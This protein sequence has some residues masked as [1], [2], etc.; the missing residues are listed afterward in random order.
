MSDVLLCTLRVNVNGFFSCHCFFISFCICILF[1]CIAGV[2]CAVMSVLCYVQ[3]VLGAALP[4][5]SSLTRYDQLQNPCLPVQTVPV[6][7][8][9]EGLVL[10]HYGRLLN[11]LHPISR[12]NTALQQRYVC[13]SITQ[14]KHSGM[15]L[16][17]FLCYS[18]H[19]VKQ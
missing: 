3:P 4:S 8:A 10:A 14:Y 1:H 6:Q 5:W 7:N 16:L 9:D 15:S 18:S 17:L 2:L 19:I 12:S 11:T 13:T